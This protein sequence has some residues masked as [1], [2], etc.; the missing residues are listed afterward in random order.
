[1]S[2]IFTIKAVSSYIGEG[3]CEGCRIFSLPVKSYKAQNIEFVIDAEFFLGEA[4]FTLPNL[5]M[6]VPRCINLFI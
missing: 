2:P 6:N 5:G 4:V 1:M 3:C